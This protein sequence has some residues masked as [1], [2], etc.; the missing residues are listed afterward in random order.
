MFFVHI[1]FILLFTLFILFLT[2]LIIIFMYCACTGFKSVNSFKSVQ[3]NISFRNAFGNDAADGEVA[4]ENTKP[5]VEFETQ[6]KLGRNVKWEV[7]SHSH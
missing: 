1:L 6:R 4:P 7:L 2:L 5:H 3:S